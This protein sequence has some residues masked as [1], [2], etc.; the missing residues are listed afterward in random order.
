MPTPVRRANWLGMAVAA[1]I[2]LVWELT[3]RL[4]IVTFDYIPA[5]TAILQRSEEMLSSGELVQNLQH[6]L[7]ATLL[8]W[9]LA[10]VVGLLLGTILGLSR[11]AWTYSMS[12][13][14][15]LRA[16]PVVAFVPVAVLLFG[17]TLKMEILVSCYSAL[18]PVLLNTLA[19]MRSTHPRLLETGSVLGMS[20]LERLWKLRL[21]AA[22]PH[23][24]VGLRL[25][26]AISLVLTLVAEMVGNPQGIGYALIAD[27]KSLQPE[28]M[29]VSIFAIGLAGIV[30][31]AMLIG[32][33]RL[34][35]RGQMASSGELT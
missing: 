33:A 21:P 28:R 2:L 7:T 13:V 29:F 17:F 31:N 5:P 32:G 3:V 34:L 30:L 12:S 8:G 35:A 20:Q 26:L 16:L 24:V 14:D 27:S 11:F 22:T 4:G 25:G 1:S 10:S 6:T 19:G 23:I 18:W 9:V 15:A